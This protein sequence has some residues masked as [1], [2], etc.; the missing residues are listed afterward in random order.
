MKYKCMI[1]NTK[2]RETP[3]FYIPYYII[4]LTN[5]ENKLQ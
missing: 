2:L 4:L 3:L 1:N 5:N